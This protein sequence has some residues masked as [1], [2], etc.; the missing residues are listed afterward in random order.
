MYLGPKIS[1]GSIPRL[2][3][4]ETASG[5]IVSL[6]QECLIFGNDRSMFSH[7]L[8]SPEVH[9]STYIAVHLAQDS[10]LSTA[11]SV[12]HAKARI[13]VLAS[14]MVLALCS[15]LQIRVHPVGVASW[16]RQ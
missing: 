10:D 8:R 16:Y 4:S 6:A 14:N 7:P 3:W 11:A 12:G 5:L 9:Q 2:L 15:V 1:G 13:L